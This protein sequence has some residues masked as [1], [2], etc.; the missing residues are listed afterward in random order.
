MK[1]GKTRALWTC[2]PV[3]RAAHFHSC[4]ELS[5]RAMLLEAIPAIYRPALGGLERYLAVLSAV[6]ALGV[7][8]LSGAAEA[9]APVSVSVSHILTHTFL[10]RHRPREPCSLCGIP[11]GKPHSRTIFPDGLSE[12]TCIF[13]YLNL[14]LALRWPPWPVFHRR[15]GRILAILYILKTITTHIT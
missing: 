13:Y 14:N 4:S 6:R 9:P 3:A 12:S 1:P 11:C 5:W 15:T 2:G 7:V 8:H 10:S